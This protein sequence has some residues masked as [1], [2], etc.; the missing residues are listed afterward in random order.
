M[1]SGACLPAAQYLRM[2][3]DHQEYSLDNQAEVIRKYAE[4]RGFEV[5][6][7]YTDNAKSGL[8]LKHRKGLAQLLS[9]VVGGPQPYRANTEIE[10]FSVFCSLPRGASSHP[11]KT[12]STRR[13]VVA[14]H[15]F[16]HSLE[17]ITWTNV[18]ALTITGGVSELYS[19][20]ARKRWQCPES[21]VSQSPS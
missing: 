13:N 4:V 15:T 21:S 10:K 12:I 9:D 8:V 5:I 1:S 14:Q 2:S 16:A 20:D 19:P 17:A 18:C 3:T 7:T 6:K 11:Q